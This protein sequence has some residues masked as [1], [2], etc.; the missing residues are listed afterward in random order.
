MFTRKG[1]SSGE[2]FDVEAFAFDF[3]L[4]QFLQL[5]NKAAARFGIGIGGKGIEGRF[6]FPDSG[7]AIDIGIFLGAEQAEANEAGHDIGRLF[8]ILRLEILFDSFFR[9]SFAT[10]FEVEAA[11]GE[12]HGFFVFW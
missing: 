11:D 1:G 3:V 7:D 4:G 10:S 2:S 8:A 12:K 6:A 9:G 5:G